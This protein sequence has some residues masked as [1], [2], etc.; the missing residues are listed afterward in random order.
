MDNAK[1]EKEGRFKAKDLIW[2]VTR[3]SVKVAI[4]YIPFE[5]FSAF[6]ASFESILGHQPF[7]I[8]LFAVFLAFIFLSELGRGTVFQHVFGIANSLVIV[9]Y[10]AH[11]LDASVIDFNVERINLMV[12]L[13]FFLAI[14]VLGG[15]LDLAKNMLRLLNWMNERE[16]RWL[17][18]QIKSL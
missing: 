15:L 17:R 10:F 3:A 8:F 13:R 1:N 18:C 5:I 4:I 14:F 7:F 16:E 12:D 6:I 2:R 11:I 9:F